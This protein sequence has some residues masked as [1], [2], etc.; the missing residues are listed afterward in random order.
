MGKKTRSLMRVASHPTLAGYVFKVF[1]VTERQCERE[2]SRGWENFPNRCKQDERI[3]AII[4]EERF[5]HFK[6]PRKWLFH[7][8]YHPSCGPNDQPLVLVA[9]YQDLLPR[10]DNEHLTRRATSHPAARTGAREAS[11]GRFRGRCL[12]FNQKPE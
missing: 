10:A 8:P 3:R 12:G 7:P 4:Q 1:F 9:E 6:A 11:C 2:K 5:Q